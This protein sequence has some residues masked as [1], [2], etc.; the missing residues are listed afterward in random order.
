MI[1][2]SETESWPELF[3]FL[4]ESAKNPAAHLRESAMLILTRLAFSASDALQQNVSHVKMLCAQ[5]LQDPESKDVRLAALS[6]T[7]S[8]VQAFS[9]YEEQVS[10]F[11]EV[12]PTMCQVL[13]GLLNENDQD[14]ARIALEEFITI[15]E[16]A[17]KFFRKHLDSLIQLAFQIATANNLEEDTRF[18]AVELLVTLAEQAPAMMRKQKIFWTTWFL[19]RCSSCSL[20]MRSTCTPGIRRRTTTTTLS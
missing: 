20:W 18:L 3:P 15:A 2:E 12:I 5:T 9:S 19:L 6:A 4:F 13:T 10:D 8:I 16:E 1:F 17:P 14:S 7:G 11:Q